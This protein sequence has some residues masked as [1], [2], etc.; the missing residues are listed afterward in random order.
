MRVQHLLCQYITFTQLYIAQQGPESR[1]DEA[2]EPV[3]GKRRL[4]LSATEASLS[5]A[6][7]KMICP[8]PPSFKN[9]TARF[10]FMTNQKIK[11]L[12]RIS[13]LRVIQFHCICRVGWLERVWASGT[14][15]LTTELFLVQK[16]KRNPRAVSYCEQ[17]SQNLLLSLTG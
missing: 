11:W 9:F 17:Y 2:S 6:Y 5:S 1:P 8:M 7:S 4:Y 16:G 12:T 13:S 15:H 10:I 3:G 14:W